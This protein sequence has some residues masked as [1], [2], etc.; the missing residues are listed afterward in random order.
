MTVAARDTEA[1]FELSPGT[2]LS[3]LVEQAPERSA[4]LGLLLKAGVG[5]HQ[6]CGRPVR[7]EAC[8]TAH[9]RA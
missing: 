8:R 5:F 4:W 9:N 6:P 3:L 7:P 1:R 2:P